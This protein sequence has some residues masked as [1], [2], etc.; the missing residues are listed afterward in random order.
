MRKK[1]TAAPRKAAVRPMSKKSVKKAAVAKKV[2]KKTAAKPVTKKAPTPA[3]APAPARH[4]KTQASQPQPVFTIKKTHQNKT[5]YFIDTLENLSAR[6]RYFIMDPV[7]A[8]TGRGRKA[9][10]PE[11]VQEKTFKTPQDL[12]E[13]LNDTLLRAGSY[14]V[15]YEV[16]DKI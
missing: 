1:T 15:H 4:K 6:L 5:S 10:K 2:I 12:V 16:T 7:P 8:K 11:P 13:A 9:E 14:D 3:P